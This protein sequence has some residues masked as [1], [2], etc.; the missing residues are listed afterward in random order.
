MPDFKKEVIILIG[1]MGAG[2]SVVGALLA[3]SLGYS[4]CDTDAM[5]EASCGMSIPQIFEHQGEAD[6]RL[7]EEQALKEALSM[8]RVVIS[9]GGGVVLSQSNQAL[10]AETGWVVYLSVSAAISKARCEVEGDTRPLL[11][12]FPKQEDWES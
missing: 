7:H 1:P 10:M 6:F 4:H 8:Q 2:K 12:R 11:A 9:T 3:E 5:V